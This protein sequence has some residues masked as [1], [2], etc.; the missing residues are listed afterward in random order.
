LPRRLENPGTCAY[1]G[2]I[3][4]KRN[5][6]RCVFGIPT[7]RNFDMIRAKVKQSKRRA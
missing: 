1:S 5:R 4:K 7:E 2:E 6:G 3:I